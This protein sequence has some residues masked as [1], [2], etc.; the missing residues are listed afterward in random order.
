MKTDSI[1]IFCGGEG[2]R[3]KNLT[4]NCPKILIDISGKP[5]L[6][7]LLK[8]F[9][10]NKIKNI[11]L[12]TK[13]KSKQIENYIKNFKSFNFFI[14]KDGNKKLGTGGSLKKNLKHLPDYFFL[15]YGDS[16]LNINYSFLRDKLTNSNKSI[17][18]IYRNK[19]KIYK[20]NILLKEK[21]IIKYDKTKNYNYIDYGLFLFKKKD[22]TPIK[23]KKKTFDLSMYLDFIIKKGDIEYII[24]K[25]KFQEC[26]S[27]DGIEKIKKIL[28]RSKN[29]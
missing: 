19:Q 10:K 14:L 18:S 17:I 1:V 28:D 22:I 16:Y 24:S 20:N 11:Y 3:I 26:G 4:K 15:T 27:Y 9:K 7:H 12:L 23:I 2:T 8:I 29:T 13:Y 6:Y 5:F 25:K 21:K